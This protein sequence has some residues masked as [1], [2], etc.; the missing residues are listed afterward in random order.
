MD[1]MPKEGTDK[2]VPK[3]KLVC[4]FINDRAPTSSYACSV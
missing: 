2:S 3:T 1:D 4:Y